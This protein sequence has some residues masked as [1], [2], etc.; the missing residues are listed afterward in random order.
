MN[1]VC[2][3]H[4][5]YAVLGMNPG[6]MKAIQVLYQL[7]YIPSSQWEL[8][9]RFVHPNGSVTVDF[10]HHMV[11]RTSSQCL[12]QCLCSANVLPVCLC[13]LVWI[14]STFLNVS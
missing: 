3:P 1:E 8:V 9:S 7:S 14:W 13:P 10:T 2:V 4:Q 11:L 5:V 6:F 12:F